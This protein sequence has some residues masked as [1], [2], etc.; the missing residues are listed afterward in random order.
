MILVYSFVL[1]VT[2]VL[3]MIF[4]APVLGSRRVPMPFR[5]L[6]GVMVSLIALPLVIQLDN[7]QSLI[8]IS[9]PT[10]LIGPMFSEAI[11]GSLLGL[12]VLI[13]FASAE[14]VGSTIGQMTGFQIDSIANPGQEFGGSPTGRLFG[15]IS[16]AVFVVIGGPELL[17]SGVLDSFIYLTPGKDI[18]GQKIVPLLGVLL[19]QSFALTVKAVGP[20]FAAILVST[21]AIGMVGRTLPQLNFLQVGLTSNLAVMFLAVFLTLGGCVWLFVDDI[22]SATHV[23]QQGLKSS[24]IDPIR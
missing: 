14:M 11:I 6:F 7:N 13:I 16:V 24:F 8:Q 5:I 1:I 2:R 19:S 18:S 23:I 3:A 20:A 4:A 15:V 21:I 17:V 9:S 10:Q 12:G 22:E